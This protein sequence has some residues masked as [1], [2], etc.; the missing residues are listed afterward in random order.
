MKNSTFALLAQLF[1][2]I[3]QSILNYIKKIS[4]QQSISV[5]TAG[6]ERVPLLSPCAGGPHVGSGHFYHVRPW[7]SAFTQRYPVEKLADKATPSCW[8]V[9]ILIQGEIKKK[10]ETGPQLCEHE[11][12]DSSGGHLGS[13]AFIKYIQMAAKTLPSHWSLQ[14]LTISEIFRLKRKEPYET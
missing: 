13:V 6:V 14:N 9:H 12:P 2:R 8:T 3:L 1:W 10:K 5:R 11:D 7:N 4:L